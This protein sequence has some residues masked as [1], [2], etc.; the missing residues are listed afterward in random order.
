MKW[1]TSLLLLACAAPAFC[2]D[3]NDL[4]ALLPPSAN[5]VFGI[6]VRAALD[7][8]LAR[9]ILSQ[10]HVNTADLPKI[11]PI[12]GFDPLTDLDEVMFASSGEGEN[13]PTLVVAHGKFDLTRLTSKGKL[14][15]GVRIIITESDNQETG[16]AIVDASTVMLGDVSEIK[17]SI[18]RR[19]TSR[20]YDQARWSQLSEYRDKYT[21]W[22]V[23]DRP[24][25]LVKKL[26]NYTPAP[27]LD[28]ID[29]L[30]FGIGLE[31]GIEIEAELH[32]RSTDDTAQ[33]TESLRLLESM[34]KA[35]R[36]SLDEGTKLTIDTKDDGTTRLALALTEE[37]LVKAMQNVKPPEVTVAAAEPVAPRKETAERKV[38]T[39]P[40]PVDHSH[41][42]GT[43]VFTLPGRR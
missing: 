40:A 2:A 38:R 32:A 13:P 4:P 34:A 31:K 28:A 17:S 8:T 5:I 21:I 35:A 7:S 16:F 39:A 43:S 6:H 29:H 41:D 19:I 33:L 14:Y 26:Q 23:A 27:T 10:M 9:G 3:S 37:Q 24:S 36:P 20:L 18:D 22:G 25:N 42:G 12:G 11:V 30:Q 15:H 1:S